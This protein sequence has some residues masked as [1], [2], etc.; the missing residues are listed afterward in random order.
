MSGWAVF[1]LTTG[2]IVLSAFF[3]VIE[4]ALM[5]ARRHRLEAEAA[6]KASARA[7][8]RGMNEL[9]LM[10]AGAQLGITACTFALGAITKPS[11]EYWLNPLFRQTGMPEWLSTGLAFGLSLFLITMLHLV[12][13]EMAPKSWA[14]AHPERS[15]KF[16]GIASR[17]YMWPIRPFL[18]WVNAI[19][20]SLVRRVGVE[21]VERAAVAGHDA[22]TIRQLVEHSVAVG[23]LEP[24]IQSQISEAIRL[25]GITAGGIVTSARITSAVGKNATVGDVQAEARASGHL[26]VLVRDDSGALVQ[27]VHVRDTLTLEGQTP[28]SS[29]ARPILRVR[30]EIPVYELLRTMREAGVQLA[31][32]GDIST[33]EQVLTIKDVIR[34]VLR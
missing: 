6:E 18:S 13:G 15:A 3:V 19:A 28:V 11:V 4:F 31:I 34:R 1:G 22:D 25:G 14:I 24:V 16:I 30:P 8:L 21:P 17:V 2:F 10:L 12:V 5:A 27:M 29:I 32:V 26:R 7:A 9:T 20:N 23:A 33:G